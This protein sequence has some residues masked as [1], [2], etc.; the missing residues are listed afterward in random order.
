MPIAMTP[1]ANF[2]IGSDQDTVY[3]INDNDGRLFDFEKLAQEE[4]WATRLALANVGVTNPAIDAAA[5]VDSRR[6]FSASVPRVPGWEMICSAARSR[7]VTPSIRN[8]Q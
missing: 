3:V 5:G 7:D 8:C 4:T 2:E 6:R 1:V